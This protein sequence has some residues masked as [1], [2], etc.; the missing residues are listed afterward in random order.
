MRPVAVAWYVNLMHYPTRRLDLDDPFLFAFEARVAAH[1][2]HG[3]APTLV[4]DQT[5]FYP[6]SGGQMADRGLLGEVAVVDVQVDDD[7]VVHH[8]VDSDGSLPDVGTRL[9]ASIDVKR[10]RFHMA[11]HTG[12]HMVSAALLE[13]AGARTVS[14]R[15]GDGLCTIDVDRQALSDEEIAKTEGRV[16]DLIDADLEVRTFFPTPEELSTMTLRRRPKVDDNVRIVA[17]GDFDLVAC[18]GTHC[19]RT[20]Q[21]GLVTLISAERY[22]GMTRVTFVAGQLARDMLAEHYR[23]LKAIAL[24]FTCAPVDVPRAIDN[25]R[26][27]L[28]EAK[29]SLHTARTQLAHLRAEELLSRSPEPTIVETFDGADAAFL[30]EVGSRI[31]SEPDRIALLAGSTPDGTTIFVARGE[32]NDFDCGAFVRSVMAA[33]GG[34]GGGR[35]SHAEGRLPASVDW[36]TLAAEHLETISAKLSTK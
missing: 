34:R 22:K 25:L 29:E 8:I 18:G 31:V 3:G 15:L 35:P 26:S 30:R 2:F 13:V 32:A 20:S 4:L 11:Q 6:E 28:S 16:N 23:V 9:S 5:A 24:G 17:V 36:S 1:R 14:S 33:A 19:S 21:V 10:R 7:G 12:Q 27:E